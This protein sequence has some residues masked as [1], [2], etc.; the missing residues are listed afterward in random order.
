MCYQTREYSR[1]CATCHGLASCRRLEPR[2]KKSTPINRSLYKTS[3]DGIGQ[4][5]NTG[6]WLKVDSSLDATAW[7]SPRRRK[8]A[9]RRSTRSSWRNGR[10]TQGEL[11]QTLMIINRNRVNTTCFEPPWLLLLLCTY[12]RLVCL[13]YLMPCFC[14]GDYIGR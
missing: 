14:L 7:F 4:I 12:A 11:E 6:W 3:F 1:A 9:F 13:A 10:Q 2:E 8:G 5:T